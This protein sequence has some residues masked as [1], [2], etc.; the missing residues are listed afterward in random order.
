VIELIPMLF[1]LLNNDSVFVI[2]EIERSLHHL[3]IKKRFALLLNHERFQN[4]QSQLIA[5]THE[6]L[7]LDIK[8]LFRKD[9]IWFI[10]RRRIS[11]LLFSQC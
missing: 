3:L 8:R 5:S 7:L 11:C 4:V 1:R 6:V 9:E 10:N 2:D